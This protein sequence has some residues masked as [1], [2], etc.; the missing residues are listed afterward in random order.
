M[1]HT[2]QSGT[3][4][5]GTVTGEA[6]RSVVRRSKPCLS[7]RQDATAPPSGGRVPAP[8]E[9]VL[10][11]DNAGRERPVPLVASGPGPYLYSLLLPP[12]INVEFKI[13]SRRL[14][15]GDGQGNRVADPQGYRVPLRTQRLQRPAVASQAVRMFRFAPQFDAVVPVRILGVA[16]AQ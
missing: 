11:V 1:K 13:S 10:L 4:L 7:E 12:D 3:G 8:M 9:V 16:N 5:V 6:L 14:S 2:R 15:I